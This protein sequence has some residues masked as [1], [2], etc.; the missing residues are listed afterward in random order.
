MISKPLKVEVKKISS[1]D[2]GKFDGGL[3]QNGPQL[4]PNNAII[5]SKDVEIDFYGYPGPRRKMVHF[6][7]DTV[8]STYQKY[9]VLW[10]DLIYYFTADQGGIYFCQEGDAGWTKCGGSNTFTTN[11]GG[12]PKFLRTLDNVLILNGKNGDRLAYADLTVSGFP[13]TKY[14]AVADP[15]VAP[16]LTSTGLGTGTQPFNVYYAYSYTS[17]VGETVLSPI[18]H[19]QVSTSRTSDG[20]TGWTSLSTPGSVTVTLGGSIPAGA[21]FW[22]VYMAVTSTSGTIQDTDMILLAPQLDLAKTEFID[23]GTLALNLNS[24]API[25]NSTSGPR[26][27]DGIVFEGIPLLFGDQDDPYAIWIGGYSIYALDFS[28]SHGGYKAEFEKGTNFYP[29]SIVGFRT[30]TGVAS[31]LVFFS[32][33]EGVSHQALLAQQTVTYGTQTFSVWTFTSQH[34]GGAGVSSSNSAVN[35]LGQLNF[36]STDGFISMDTA[37]SRFNV[38]SLVPISHPIREYVNSIKVSAMVHVVGCAWENKFA[39]LIPS[40]GFD[41][42]Q[43]ILIYDLNNPGIGGKGAWYTLDIPAN[44]IGVVTPSNEPAFVYVSQGKSTYKLTDTGPTYDM[45]EGV[46]TTFSTSITGPIISVSG[47][48]HN[49]WMALVQTVF[50]FINLVGTVTVGVNYWTQDGVMKTKTFTFDGPAYVPSTA[51][52]WGDPQWTYSAFPQVDGW[53]ASVVVPVSSLA[54]NAVS[55]RV[56]VNIDDIVNEFQYF[57]NTSSGYNDYKFKSVS[58]EG[59]ELGVRPDLN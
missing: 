48:S 40:Y 19:I 14:T 27:E 15:T 37:A 54:T 51:E 21:K 18:Q 20:S 30:G 34:Q 2:I 10:N 9:P 52:G 4:A 17:Q 12:M 1:V 23:N 36:L 29:N 33:T 47:E 3:Y 53:S 50:Y 56:K 41:T 7:P 59:I 22:N 58:F 28:I 8:E 55:A 11:N 42:P 38:L 6:L 24:L 57:L 35:Y 13:I 25:A 49:E 16:T 5:D 39:W 32:N 45:I 26:V 31:L 43:D 44:W 46:P